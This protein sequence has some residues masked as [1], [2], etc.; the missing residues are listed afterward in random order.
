MMR[1]R[2]RIPLIIL[3]VITALTFGA[4]RGAAATLD[5]LGVGWDKS[6]IT[7]LIKPVKGVTPQAVQDVEAA[8][9]DWVNAL[10]T[11]LPSSTV[12]GPVVTDVRGIV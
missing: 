10:Q 6:V 2:T 8:V 11:V 5:L 1:N 12:G 3:S 9:S 4:K 7:V